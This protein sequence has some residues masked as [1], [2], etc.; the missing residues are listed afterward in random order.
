[1]QHDLPLL[2]PS[3][4]RPF[5]EADEHVFSVDV[6]PDVPPEVV[7]PDVPPEVVPPDVPPEVV[8]PDVPPELC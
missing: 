5:S 1:M 6:L 4:H 3:R 2:G 7:P 8:P